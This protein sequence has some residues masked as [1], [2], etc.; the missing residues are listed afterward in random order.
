M[1][2][3]KHLYILFNEPSKSKVAYYLNIVIYTLIIIS[4]INLM[5]ISVESFNSKYGDFFLIIRNTIMPI[6]IIEYLLRVYAAGYDKKYKGF[7]GVLKYIIT[8]YAIIDLVSILPYILVNIG[9]DSSSVRALRLLRIFRLLRARKYNIFIQLMKKI[10]SNLKEE[11]IVLFFFTIILLIVLAVIIY[12]IEHAAQ[13]E[14]FTNIFQ[15]IWWS[16]ATL[17]TVGYGDMYPVTIVGKIITSIISIIGIAFI[18]IPGGLFASEFVLALEEQKKKDQHNITCPKCN[19]KLIQ[20]YVDPIVSY[21][22][23]N[24]N[25]NALHTC[26]EC[27]FSWLESTNNNTEI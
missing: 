20:S 6:F 25:F 4:I 2:I 14:V 27:R 13:P 1:T 15:S 9:F 3:Q 10:L 22:N 12:E 18:A 11:L 23:E 19:N 21:N 17:T 8:P 7:K 5:L 24:H 26:I 16:V